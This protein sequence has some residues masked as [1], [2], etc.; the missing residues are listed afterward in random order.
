MQAG[1]RHCW[2]P[3]SLCSSHAS[4]FAFCLCFVFRH[5]FLTH[6]SSHSRALHSKAKGG[7]PY[8]M[9]A[10]RAFLSF[11]KGLNKQSNSKASRLRLR[12]ER[13]TRWLRRILS[14][15]CCLHFL[16]LSLLL[17]KQNNRLNSWFVLR[18]CVYICNCIR[19]S[20]T[21]WLY[22]LGVLSKG[23]ARQATRNS[24]NAY[25]LRIRGIGPISNQDIWPFGI[26]KGLH[27]FSSSN[28]CKAARPDSVFR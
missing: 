18:I 4:C 6:Y 22:D 23:S 8:Q 27:A 11:L 20:L 12:W 28:R 16:L 26:L 24:V 15:I 3:C 13:W 7:L 5:W 9:R 2:V 21:N 25:V 17:C 10:L 19:D 14:N 1:R